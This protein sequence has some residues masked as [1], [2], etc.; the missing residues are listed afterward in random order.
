M[1]PRRGS[2]APPGREPGRLHGGRNHE[3][4]HPN[5]VAR[6]GSRTGR[7]ARRRAPRRGSAERGLHHYGRTS[8]VPFDIEP[9]SLDRRRSGSGTLG[10]QPSSPRRARREEGARVREQRLAPI[11]ARVRDHGGDD[12]LRR[13]GMHG[14]RDRHVAVHG[15]VRGATRTG[16]FTAPSR[17]ARSRTLP[18]SRCVAVSGSSRWRGSPNRPQ[19]RPLLGRRAVRATAA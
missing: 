9:M 14:T 18:R 15:A 7:R 16:P 8:H 11:E 5:D 1:L 3:R 4:H 12:P 19:V 6:R 17:R 10:R 13:S 2:S